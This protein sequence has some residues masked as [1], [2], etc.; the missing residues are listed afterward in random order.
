MGLYNAN[1]TMKLICKQHY[2]NSVGQDGYKQLQDIIKAHKTHNRLNLMEML[3]E[4]FI[5][6]HIHGIRAERARRN[7]AQ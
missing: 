5:A 4:A 1:S 3:I 7:K 6:G 2:S